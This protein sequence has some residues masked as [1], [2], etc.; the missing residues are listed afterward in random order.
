MFKDLCSRRY[1]CLFWI[2]P[3]QSQRFFM[4]REMLSSSRYC[5]YACVE[6]VFFDV[7]SFKASSVVSAILF[8]VYETWLEN[9]QMTKLGQINGY[10]SET[11][12][13]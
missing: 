7:K 6:D 11:F 10:G 1:L 2:P 9:R 8:F 3:R 13:L 4:G 5:I 12:H